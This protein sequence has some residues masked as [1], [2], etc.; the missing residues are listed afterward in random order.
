[1]SSFQSC[2]DGSQ[3]SYNDEKTIS[4]CFW[5]MTSELKLLPIWSKI[6]QPSEILYFSSKLRWRIVACTSQFYEFSLDEIWLGTFWL[7]RTEDPLSPTA[8]S[9]D[10]LLVPACK[11]TWKC[12][13]IIALLNFWKHLNSLKSR[14]EK[15]SFVFIVFLSQHISV[16][17]LGIMGRNK[18]SQT[19]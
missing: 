18:W 19:K 8:Q 12:L 16:S 1:M 5:F 10:S 15:C 3:G 11:S 13:R 7:V 17:H 6:Q 14:N 2:V 9:L 4:Y